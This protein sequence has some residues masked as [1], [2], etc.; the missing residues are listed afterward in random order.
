MRHIERS[1]SEVEIST[2]VFKDI[3]ITVA[4]D[5]STAFTSLCAVTFVQDD[6]PSFHTNQGRTLILIPKKEIN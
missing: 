2:R 5:L 1:Q 4:I 3:V 6:V